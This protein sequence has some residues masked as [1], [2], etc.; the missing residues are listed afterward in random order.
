MKTERKMTASISEVLYYWPMHTS[1]KTQIKT[2]DTVLW[3]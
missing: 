3:V 1:Q 2:L